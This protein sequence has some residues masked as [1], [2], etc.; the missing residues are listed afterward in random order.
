MLA[1]DHDVVRAGPRE[2]CTRDPGIE[3]TGKAGN[4]TDGAGTVSACRPDVLQRDI[5][6]PIVLEMK[7]PAAIVSRGAVQV[8]VGGHV[9]KDYVRQA[10]EAGH[11]EEL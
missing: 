8:G 1:G 4:G 9:R 2:A 6:E 7:P 11:H 5:E 3:C 10:L